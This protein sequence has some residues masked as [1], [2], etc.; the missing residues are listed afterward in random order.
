MLRRKDGIN[1][2]QQQLRTLDA[3]ECAETLFECGAKI[4]K[5]TEPR[6]PIVEECYYRCGAIH[7]RTLLPR[8]SRRA[9]LRP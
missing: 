6:S 1:P 4:T 3:C 9:A 7:A 8:D 2:P 5:W